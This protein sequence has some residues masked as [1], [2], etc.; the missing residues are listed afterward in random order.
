VSEE[1][2]NE[3]GFL[4]GPVCDVVYRDVGLYDVRNEVWWLS[5]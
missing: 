4:D 3:L 2:I 5:K 1:R